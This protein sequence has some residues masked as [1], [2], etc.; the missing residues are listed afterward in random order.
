MTCSGGTSDRH[1]SRPS[2]FA[3]T[4]RQLDHDASVTVCLFGVA[5]RGWG[6]NWRKGDAYHINSDPPGYT[7]TRCA[8]DV[9]Y[10][11]EV[12]RGRM[13]VSTHTD[14]AEAKAAAVKHAERWDAGA[15]A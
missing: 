15:P 7:I 12:W 6:V 1:F 10:R 2:N 13:H 3:N 14:S 5:H 4:S 11:Y 9:G 8:I